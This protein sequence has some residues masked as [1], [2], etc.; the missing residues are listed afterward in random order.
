MKRWCGVTNVWLGGL[1]VISLLGGHKVAAQPAEVVLTFD[2]ALAQ[3]VTQ[4]I[5]V[6]RAENQVAFDETGVAQARASFLPDLSFSLSPTVR[7]DRGYEAASDAISGETGESVGLT[8]SSSV[9]VFDGFARR[10]ALKEATHL[11]EASNQRFSR[12]QERILFQTAAQYL[13]VFQQ[14]A[15]VDVE[16][17]NLLALQEQLAQIQAF[18]DAGNRPVADVL[19]QRAAIARSEQRLL[20]VLQAQAVSELELKRLLRMD[21]L[22]PIRLAEPPQ[23]VLTWEHAPMT[24]DG[25][26]QAALALRSDLEAQ[27]LDIEASKAGVDEAKAGYLPSVSVGASAGTSYSSFNQALGFGDQFFNAGGTSNLSFSIALPILDRRRTRSN[28]ERARVALANEQLVLEQEVQQVA[29]EVQRAILDYE[30]T[31]AQLLAATQQ[32]IA[33]EEALNATTARYDVGASTLIEVTEARNVYREAQASQV[34]AEFQ[35]AIDRLGIAYQ[36][37]DVKGLLA[38]LE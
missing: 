17:D 1:I 12:T 32:V 19:Q 25:G 11:W 22:T 28:V 20:A 5:D 29:F 16:E 3:A 21:P 35:V 23:A 9:Q 38:S 27:R 26:V 2:E 34:E 24:A 6:V 13:S 15:L 33:A 4:N 10:S 18:F 31:Q 30:T 14:E 8:A 36:T 7:Y 37:G